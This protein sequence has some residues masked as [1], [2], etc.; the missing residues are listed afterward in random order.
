M[1]LTNIFP[2]PLLHQGT[3]NPT[4]LNETGKSVTNW[5][6]WV[7]LS[8]TWR[9]LRDGHS[10]WQTRGKPTFGTDTLFTQASQDEATQSVTFNSLENPLWHLTI[11]RVPSLGVPGIC[12][13][14]TCTCCLGPETLSAPP[15][16]GK[17]DVSDEHELLGGWASDP[18][19]EHLI[20]GSQSPATYTLTP[21][22]PQDPGPDKQKLPIRKWS[23]ML[24]TNTAS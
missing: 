11:Y 6:Q 9:Q 14:R 3:T 17:Q 22:V 5:V 12:Y 2:R 23:S 19:R 18:L 4:N 13:R 8:L 24:P 1:W 7:L 10:L 20:L 15:A 21:Q 16:K